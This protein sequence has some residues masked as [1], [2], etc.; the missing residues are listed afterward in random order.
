MAGLGDL[1]DTIL[2]RSIVIQM[3]R[4]ARN[5]KVKAFRQ[6]YAEKPGSALHNRLRTWSKSIMS[7]IGNPWP[8]MP[9]GIEDRD[10]DVWEALFAVANVAGGDWPKKTQDA[11]LY[12]VNAAKERP[13]S[14]GIRLLADLRIIF[15]KQDHLTTDQIITKLCDLPET[16]WGVIR[17][18]EPIDSRGVSGRLSKYGVKSTTV[19]FGK[20]DKDVAR[21]YKYEDLTDPWERYLPPL[22]EEKKPGEDHVAENTEDASSTPSPAVTATS[23]T[24]ATYAAGKPSEFEG[25]GRPASFDSMVGG[26]MV[27]EDDEDYDD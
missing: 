11:A 8:E 6:R 26:V 3:R 13:A 1:P 20:G 15:G 23:A 5:E 21:G 27:S 25:S 9:E 2:T 18:G 16:P 22:E 4:R 7:T 24:S 19:R 14:L 10:A 12:L 17:K